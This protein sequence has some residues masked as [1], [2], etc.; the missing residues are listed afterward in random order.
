MS[1]NTFSKPL[2]LIFLIH[3]GI[4]KKLNILKENKDTA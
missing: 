1:V 2:S 3:K 4:R